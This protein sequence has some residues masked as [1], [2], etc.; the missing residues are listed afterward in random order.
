MHFITPS[1]EFGLCVK[2]KKY[3]SFFVLYRKDKAIDQKNNPR[4]ERSQK[5][6]IN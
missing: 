5:Q 2:Q 4:N 6:A 1:L 3:N